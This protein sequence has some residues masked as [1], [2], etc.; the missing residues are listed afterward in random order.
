MVRFSGFSKIVA[1]L[2]IIFEAS[3]RPFLVSNILFFRTFIYLL[4]GYIIVR[5]V[6]GQ[7]QQYTR[8]AQANRQLARYAVT[9]EQLTTSRERNRMARELHD[10][11]AHTLSAVSI[12]LEAVSAL[13]ENNPGKARGM[14][15]QSL[16]MT[17]DGL[18]ESRRAIQSLRA[19]PLED[20]GLSIA[21]GN[22]ARSMSERIGLTLDLQL[23]EDLPTLSPEVEHS[24]YRISEE[25]LRNVAEHAN[26]T[27]VEVHLGLEDHHVML[28]IKDDG[29]GFDE[30]SATKDHH[31]GL[32][33]MYEYA[34]AI[35]AVLTVNSVPQQGTSIQLNLEVKDDP[36]FN[37]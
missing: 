26:A 8:L 15:N 25:A 2:P 34:S 9:L 6:A 11:L 24:L 22:L 13:W 18:N 36:G 35:G 7:R 12:E 37:L 4:V 16:T 3:P 20:L 27:Q 28:T 31:Y 21:L 1:I 19:A 30:Q 10:T 29:C 23:P 5:L 32:R 14:L 33:G 17:R